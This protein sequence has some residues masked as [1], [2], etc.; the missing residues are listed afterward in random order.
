MVCLTLSGAD[1][2]RQLAELGAALATTMI[3]KL[4]FFFFRRI[5]LVL[6]RALQP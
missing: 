3:G 2:A 1:A 4:F 6:E 5:T